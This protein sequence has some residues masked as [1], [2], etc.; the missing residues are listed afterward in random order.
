MISFLSL[1]IL[2]LT[3]RRYNLWSYT[4]CSFLQFPI[5]FTHKS[6]NNWSAPTLFLNPVYSLLWTSQNKCHTD[7][8]ENTKIS[9]NAR[10]H[11]VYIS[12]VRFSESRKESKTFWSRSEHYC[13]FLLNFLI[14]QSLFLNSNPKYFK[15]YTLS[16]FHCIS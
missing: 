9:A 3:G 8:Y 15:F 16:K 1:I 13:K 10:T 4:L 11:T 5:S 14:L 6:L 2:I 7:I 12:I